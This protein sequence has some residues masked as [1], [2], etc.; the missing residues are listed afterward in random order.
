MNEMMVERNPAGDKLERLGV[1]SW[2]IWTKEASTFD[3]Y[4]D[5]T[6]TCYLLD[7]KVRVEPA[8]G[9]AVE[10]GAGDLVTFP[11]GTSCIW[12]I[13]SAVRKHYSFG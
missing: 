3:W 6:E 7:G 9:N 4:Y 11:K 12:K 2:P 10:F 8:G 1:F 13:A 5:E